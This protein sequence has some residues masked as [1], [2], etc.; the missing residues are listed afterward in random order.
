MNTCIIGGNGFIGKHLIRELIPTG[1]N[2]TVVG[3]KSFEKDT[4]PQLQIESL[5]D[6]K[7]EAL[8]NKN[9]NEVICL[10]YATKPKTSFDNPIMDIEENLAQ[11]LHLFE[12]ISKAKQVKKIIYI[13]SGGAIYGNTQDN[14]ISEK[15]LTNPI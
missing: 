13:S 12:I 15:H 4:L 8:I 1:R 2:I 6:K 7:L 3:R 11:T 10:A 14:L 5:F 9:I